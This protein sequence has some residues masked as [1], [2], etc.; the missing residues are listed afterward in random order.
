[1]NKLTILS[2]LIVAVAILFTNFSCGDKVGYA[3]TPDFNSGP[4]L[5][6]KKGIDSIYISKNNVEW[7]FLN[8]TVDGKQLLLNDKS[9]ITETKRSSSGADEVYLIR[10]EWFTMEKLDNKRMHVSI[11]GNEKNELRR[12]D[13][14]IHNGNGFREISF[15]QDIK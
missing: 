4:H 5:I 15:K 1:M 3:E 12:L 7:Q 8:L 11:T 14:T 10:G 9:I 13:I 6:N 2:L